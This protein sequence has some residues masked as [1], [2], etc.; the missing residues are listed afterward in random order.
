MLLYNSLSD[1]WAERGGIPITPRVNGTACSTEQGI[2][3]GLGWANG[4][5]HDDSL[6]LR[7]WWSYAPKTDTWA[8]LADFP[9]DKSCAA[10]CWTDNNAIWVAGGFK[11]YSNEIWR[12]DIDSN[13]WTAETSCYPQRVMS[14]IAAQCNGRYFSGTGF[15]TDSRSGWWEWYRD[16]TWERRAS[17]PGRGR[18][19]AACAS[20][21]KSVWVF[22]GWH[23][24]DSLTT[25]FY[26]EDILRYSPD[27]DQWTYCGAM[28]CGTTENGVAYGIGNT[29]YWGL[30]EDKHGHIHNEW[31]RIDE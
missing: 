30:G 17:V 29:V 28:P 4:Y 25:G 27:A 7:D 14:P 16:G 1:Q 9:S 13:S 6:Y 19:N 31:Y 23:Y 5:I 22:G 10:V 15:H 3:L 20:T 11:G 2:Y 18:H 12:Y 24:G 21:D 26:Y 8:R